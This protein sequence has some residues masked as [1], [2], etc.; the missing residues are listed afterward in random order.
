MARRYNGDFS[1]GPDYAEY[2]PH[3]IY[4]Q[5]WNEPNRD[6]YWRPQYT[7]GKIVSAGAYRTLVTQM[8]NAV[9]GVNPANRSSPA[10]SRRSAGPG[11]PRRWRS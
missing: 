6:Y 8:T 1:P 9:H 5:A 7:S 11:S 2:L 10:A 4:Y 3:V